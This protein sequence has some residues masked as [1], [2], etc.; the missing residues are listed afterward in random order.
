MS[1]YGSASPKTRLYCV[2]QTMSAPRPPC[3][4]FLKNSCSYGDSCRNPHV[5]PDS[6]SPKPPTMA[7]NVNSPA[8]AYFLRGRC[9]FGDQCREFHPPSSQSDSAQE[10]PIKPFCRYFDRGSC[11]KG[12]K[13]PFSHDRGDE[14]RAPEANIA[15]E[16]EA[17]R[18][19]GNQETVPI[20]SSGQR[21]SE[22]VDGQQYNVRDTCHFP[23]A[24]TE[25]RSKGRR[26]DV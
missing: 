7:S 17:N 15:V 4:F 2:L 8:C 16:I 26:C 20:F 9:R 6:M 19:M 23:C 3:V 24:Q 10:P 1:Q 13:C 12:N 21:S 5:K 11:I 18:S 22:A 25:E 14:I